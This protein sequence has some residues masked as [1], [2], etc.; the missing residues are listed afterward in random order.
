[1]SNEEITIIDSK[2][3]AEEWDNSSEYR[4]SV[5]LH[6]RT[7]NKMKR[8]VPKRMSLEECPCSS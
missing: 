8:K 6:A 2:Q 1:M 5:E 3:E 7:A 4:F